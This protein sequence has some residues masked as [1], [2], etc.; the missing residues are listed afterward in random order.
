MN[1]R[2]NRADLVEDFQSYKA[3]MKGE[4]KSANKKVAVKSD[5]AVTEKLRPSLLNQ[6]FNES[7]VV[8]SITGLTAN[9]LK[10]VLNRPL[11]R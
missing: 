11:L 8:Y 5:W 4:S 3:A 7:L 6:K 9:S 1:K 2:E 10:E